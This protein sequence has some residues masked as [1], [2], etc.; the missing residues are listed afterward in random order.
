MNFG[1]AAGNYARVQWLTTLQFYKR[2]LFRHLVLYWLNKQNSTASNKA[3]LA[4][5]LL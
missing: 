5:K 2:S 3:V 4:Q 1:G